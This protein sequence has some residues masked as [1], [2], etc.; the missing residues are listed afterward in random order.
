MAET[1]PVQW[2]TLQ[3][4]VLQAVNVLQICKWY[5]H[6]DL[7]LVLNLAIAKPFN[8]MVSCNTMPSG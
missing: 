5:T 6:L 3:G 4:R 1:H 7:V 2:V 8:I